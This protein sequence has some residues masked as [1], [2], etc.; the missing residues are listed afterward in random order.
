MRV[1][2]GDRNQL[3]AHVEGLRKI[4]LAFEGARHRVLVH[5][6]GNGD[7]RLLDIIEA[8]QLASVLVPAAGNVNRAAQGSA[9]RVIAISGTLHAIA[10]FGKN[11]AVDYCV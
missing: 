11:L 6:A 9:E 4:A 2:I 3:S 5:R 10:V 8:E 1:G 7:E